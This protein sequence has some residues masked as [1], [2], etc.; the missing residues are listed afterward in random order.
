MGKKGPSRHLK[1]HP[2]PSFWPINRKS[3]AWSIRTSSGPHSLHT[4]MPTGV[5]LRDELKYAKSAKEAKFII[6][7]GKLIVDGKTRLDERF[8]VG[9]MDVISIPDS[10]E[11]FR[12]LPDHGGKLKLLPI[13]EDDAKYK[14][15]RI[16]GKMTQPGG[17][18]QLNFHDGYNLVVSAEEDSYKVNDVLKIKV[19]EKEIVDHIEFKEMQQSIVTGG[20][21][22][23]AQGM[24][25][26]VGPEPGWKKTCIIRTAEGEDI[27]TLA[28]YVFAVGSKE[29]LIALQAGEE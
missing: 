3:G 28:R 9:L 15:V 2:S 8:P 25:I 20:R 21:S 7:Q 4:S 11:F 26:G 14:L 12:V 1:R 16:T 13:T 27:R 22:Q 19:Q 17:K 5:V 24:I 18:T 23:G 10:K 6:K 29:P